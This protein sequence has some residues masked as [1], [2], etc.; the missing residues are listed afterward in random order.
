[1][2]KVFE[3]NAKLNATPT[4]PQD[5]VNVKWVTDYVEGKVK[6]P[7]RAVSPANIAGTYSPMTLTA[8]ATGAAVI[9]GVT[10]AIGDRVLLIGQTDATQNGIYTVTVVGDGSTAAEYTRANDFDESGKIYSGVRIAVNEGTLYAD[11]DFRLVTDGVIVLDSTALTFI[12]DTVPT[13]VEKYT[14]TITGDNTTTAFAINHGLGTSDVTIAIRD[15]ST[16][17]EV[18]T[19]TAITDNNNV[20]L[21]FANAPA[22]T[23]SYRVIIMG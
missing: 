3:S 4:A 14:E 9:D 7:V 16:G 6:A 13:G 2:A 5:I 20:T 17:D 10:L 21:T 1:M 18:F 12:L 23:K 22:S 19:D 11:K 15:N 8:G